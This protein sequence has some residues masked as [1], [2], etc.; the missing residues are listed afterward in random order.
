[1]A[2]VQLLYTSEAIKPQSREDLQAILNT[3]VA[4]NKPTGITGLLL[5]SQG[6][7]I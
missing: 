7:F 4:N 3:S 5:Y 1:M 2:I 6:N